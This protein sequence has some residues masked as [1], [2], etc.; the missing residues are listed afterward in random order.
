MLGYFF[1]IYLTLL[2]VLLVSII[3]ILCII[4]V[5]NT[6]NIMSHINP[7]I[8]SYDDF[9][10]LYYRDRY[11][12]KR[13]LN[14]WINRWNGIKPVIQAYQKYNASF[15]GIISRTGLLESFI[16]RY[17]DYLFVSDEHDK[18]VKYISNVFEDGFGII[19]ERNDE[20]VEKE[21]I[22][23]EDFFDSIFSEPL[24][25]QQRKCI[26]VDEAHNLVVAGAGTGKTM[27]ILGKVGY[28]LK[29]GVVTPDEVLMMSFGRSARDEMAERIESTLDA[30]VDVKT[31]HSLGYHIIGQVTGAKPSI[32]KDAE[33]RGVLAQRFNRIL[34]EFIEKRIEDYDFLDLINRFFTYYSKPVENDLDFRS[35]EEYEAYLQQ[36]EIRTLQGEK[37]KSYEEC[38]IAN[39]LYLNGI[40][41]EYE[42]DYIVDTTTQD[43]RRY[44]PD[45][46]LPDYGI[47]IEHFGVDRD[48]NTSQDVDNQKYIDDIYWKRT[49]HLVYSTHLI[50]TYSYERSEGILISNLID[51]LSPMGVEYKPIPREEIF[52]NIK[53][54]G[55]VSLFVGLLAK[56]LNLF[57]SSQATIPE[58]RIK[59]KKYFN[60]KRYHAFLDIFE[61]IY[62]DYES[63]LKDSG[64][65]DFNDMIIQATNYVEIGDFATRYK[66]ILVDEFQDISQSRYKFLKS[67]LDQDEECRLFCVGDDWQSIYRFTGSDL[68]I[69]T[70]FE[71][72]FGF[73][74]ILYL[75]ETFRNNQSIS[76]FSSNFIMKN[77]SQ[78]TKNI[79]ARPA[80]FKAISVVWYDDLNQGILDTIQMI[81]SIEDSPAEVL[82]LG[83]YNQEFYKVERSIFNDYPRKLQRTLDDLPTSKLGIKYL[84]IHRSKG[85]EADYVI[86]I[87]LRSGTYGFPCEIEDDPVLK[88][89]LSQEDMYTN[90][91]E[92]RLFYVGVSRA[93]KRVFL[94]SDRSAIS[95]FTS[96]SLQD[97]E[98]VTVIGE[99][100]TRVE[101]PLCGK[102]YINRNP[103]ES[104][105]FCSNPTCNYQPMTCP[106]CDSGFLYQ[107]SKNQSSY[108]CS[109][110][111]FSARICPRCN[112]G[113]LVIHEKNGRF[114]GCSNYFSKECRFTEPIS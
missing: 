101:C 72:H 93:K 59:A 80:D 63:A 99:E 21:L 10:S 16:L 82:V 104:F 70:E 27:T 48:W 28:L 60:W 58:L 55:D 68:A 61:I 81:D 37:V 30:K 110:C 98:N 2:I 87:G 15:K 85:T 32:S 46:Y 42:K 107:D 8:K 20:F 57:K 91:E 105:Y 40:K 83:R 96:E 7:I 19:K 49:T 109:K 33:D 100:P 64:R 13:D 31:F 44:Q 53:R 52:R 17:K 77:P 114:W 92:R 45:F 108:L 67:L 3:V 5:Y 94:L 69:M 25:L 88:L 79:R 75:E 26:I 73:N 78:Y 95:S 39:F 65:I 103:D 106:K 14:G 18:K 86:F 6:N 22:S 23:Y 97:R 35:E 4:A 66:Y 50:E 36:C 56:F 54:L 41:Y 11:F 24:T 9:M 89:V 43:R 1:N 51:K 29:K 38:M 76:N 34:E 12:S 102:G 111:T 112:E 113:Y 71:R 62:D 74:E 90:A 84:T 47:W